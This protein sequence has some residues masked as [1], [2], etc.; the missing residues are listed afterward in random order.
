MNRFSVNPL[1]GFNP[2]QA[3]TNIKQQNRE[4]DAQKAQLQ[5]DRDKRLAF[6]NAAS[7]DPQAMIKLAEADPNLF[8]WM[9]QRNAK[10][11]ATEGAARAQ[12]KQQA[13]QQWL[14]RYDQA[15]ESEDE[16]AKQALMQEAIDDPNNDLEHGAIGKDPMADRAITKAILFNSMGKDAYNQFYGQDRGLEKGVFSITQTP[17]GFLRLNNK[18]GQVTEISSSSKEAAEARKAEKERIEQELK[19]SNTTFDRSKKIRDRYDKQS[20]DFVKVRDA[21]GRIEA[22]SSDPDPAGDLSLIFNY[23]KMLDPG[24]TVREGEFATAEGA[25]SVPERFKGAYNKVISGEKLTEKQRNGF[26]NRAKMLMKKANSQQSKDKAEAIRLGK[27]FGITENDI[28]G[29]QPEEPAAN[30]VNWSDL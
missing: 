3:V 21:F 6:A 5:A 10:R 12:I 19:Q 17:T 4:E 18:T 22:S 9:D 11:A 16:Q 8:Q 2:V 28:F 26:V 14:I 25:A 24:S 20:G 1:G 7:G 23:M 13:E 15:L 29:V 30:A 27:Q